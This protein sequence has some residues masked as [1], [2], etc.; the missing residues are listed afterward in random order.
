MPTDMDWTR[1]PLPRLLFPAL[2]LLALAACSGKIWL[3]ALQTRCA[4]GGTLPA[5][6]DETDFLGTGKGGSRGG[7]VE[8]TA[9]E[10]ARRSRPE[11]SRGART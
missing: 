3:S 6:A 9:G 5:R 10:N 2:G 1:A 7:A 4:A 11:F 8:D